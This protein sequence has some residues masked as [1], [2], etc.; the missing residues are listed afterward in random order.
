MF[1]SVEG[2]YADIADDSLN[3]N[4]KSLKQNVISLKQDTI[5]GLVS[6]IYDILSIKIRNPYNGTNVE[7][8]HKTSASWPSAAGS[9][10]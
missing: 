9:L 6:Y 4:V 5:K 8:R 10:G 2:L 7:P 1:G 3:Q